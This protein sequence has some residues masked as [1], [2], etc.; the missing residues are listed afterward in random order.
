MSETGRS[1]GVET[2]EVAPRDALQAAGPSLLP[3]RPGRACK[4]GRKGRVALR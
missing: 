3:Q 1:R 4:T 2:L